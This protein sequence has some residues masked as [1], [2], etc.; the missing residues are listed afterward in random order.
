M[1]SIKSLIGLAAFSVL[2]V[3]GINLDVT[4]TDSIK[5]AA[6]IIAKDLVGLY[7][8]SQI[9][10]APIGVLNESYSWWESGAMFDTLIQYWRLTGDSQYNQLVTQGLASQRGP[11]DDFMPLNQTISIGSDDQSIWALAAISAAEARLGGDQNVSWFDLAQATFDEQVLR[12]DEETCNGGLRWKILPFNAGY[13]YKNT[14]ATGNFFQL[15]ARLAVSTNNDTYAEW[16]TTAWNWTQTAGLID[17]DH[18]V[19]DGADVSTDCSAIN[20]L[21]FSDNAGT[22]IAGAAYMYNYTDGDIKWKISL[23]SL[24]NRTMSV[25][26]PSGIATE[27]ACESI[28][29][30][31]TDQRASKGVL[32]K[33]LV[34][35]IAIA[36]HTSE[37]ITEQL[38]SSAQ[39]AV[40]TCGDDGCGLDWSG[41]AKNSSTGVGEQINALNY[42]QGLLQSHATIQS[43]SGETT[44]SVCYSE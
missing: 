22:F 27:T 24:V 43:S 2:Q 8:E 35:T 5:S 17:E 12:W 41:N 44:D 31:T 29:S 30:C 28:N 6:S 23:D 26:F 11:N 13:S 19:F 18:N 10:G 15:A 4:S 36:P 3:Q 40:K 21:Q 37:L 7:K 25:F 1:F 32:G 34:D 9:P 14:M 39:A 20:K 16:A 42:V 33:W 38:I